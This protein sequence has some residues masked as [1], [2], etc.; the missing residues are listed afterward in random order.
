MADRPTLD[1]GELVG[2]VTE[3][4]GGLGIGLTGIGDSRSHEELGVFLTQVHV[5]AVERGVDRVV[6]DMRDLEFLSSSCIKQTVN[7]VLAAS[8]ARYRIHIVTSAQYRW[9]ATSFATLRRLAPET[10]SMESLATER[11]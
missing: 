10:V 3:E 5:L 6:A 4:D 8:D 1:I 2:A 11:R 9:Q 7:W